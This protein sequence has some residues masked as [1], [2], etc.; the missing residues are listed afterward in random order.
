LYQ[1]TGTK[2]YEGGK[3]SG[4]LTLEVRQDNKNAKQLYKCLGFK[5]CKPPMLFWVKNI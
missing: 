2:F 3:R 5:D 1:N 4:K